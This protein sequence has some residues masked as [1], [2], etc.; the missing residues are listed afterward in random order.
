MFQSILIMTKGT[1]ASPLNIVK[2]T[3]MATGVRNYQAGDRVTWIHWKSFART[4][5]LM[6]KEFEDRRSQELFLVMDG[7]NSEVFEDLVELD[8]FYLERSLRASGGTGVDD[9]RGGDVHL[10][11]HPIGRATA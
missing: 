3:T 11:V 9:N 5:T 10:P 1:I 7:R 2:D 4:Q 6:T 8:C